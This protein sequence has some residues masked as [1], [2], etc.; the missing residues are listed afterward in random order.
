MSIVANEQGYEWCPGKL[1]HSRH[2]TQREGYCDGCGF[3]VPRRFAGRYAL[4]TDELKRH[5][6]KKRRADV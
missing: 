4:S 1:D 3:K 2:Y 6:R 5:Y